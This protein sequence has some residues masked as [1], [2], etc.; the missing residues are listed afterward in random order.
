[1][2]LT[3]RKDSKLL[4]AQIVP[5]CMNSRTR[6]DLVIDRSAITISLEEYTISKE[7]MAQWFKKQ[8]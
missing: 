7:A 8:L 1:M 5:Y 6:A 2:G 4:L 3:F